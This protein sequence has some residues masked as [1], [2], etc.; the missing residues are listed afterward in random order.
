MSSVTEA[1][2]EQI[3]TRFHEAGFVHIRLDGPADEGDLVRIAEAFGR[4]LPTDRHTLENPVIQ[5]VSTDGLF[6]Q[7]E[8]PWHNDWS[9][10]RGAFFGTLLYN[11]E[12]AHIAPTR[13]VDMEIAC[14]KLPVAE[15]DRLRSV[16]GHYSPPQHLATECFSPRQLRALRRVKASR[17]FV[18]D[19]PSTG[20]PVLYFSP[21]TLRDVSGGPADVPALIRHCEPLAWPHSW[22]ADE[23][24]LYDNLRLMHCRPAFRGRRVLWRIQFDPNYSDTTASSLLDLTGSH[25]GVTT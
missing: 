23:V 6:G 21:G 16:T 20:R 18:F 10:G 17:P 1:T 4:L 14:A 7:D 8:V 5:V 9:Y 19:H 3:R 13:F 22:A 2:L 25:S 24:L 12:N 11:R 15:R